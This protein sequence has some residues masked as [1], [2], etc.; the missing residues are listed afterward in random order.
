MC[1]D[2]DLGEDTDPSWLI[3]TEQ[4]MDVLLRWQVLR[5]S[6]LEVHQMDVETAFLNVV[7][8]EEVY[9]RIP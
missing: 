4:I 5:W 3:A 9:I 8:E 7:L 1:V 2:S 6:L